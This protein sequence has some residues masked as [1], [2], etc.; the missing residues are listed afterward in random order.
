MPPCSYSDGPRAGKGSAT[1]LAA[2]AAGAEPEEQELLA[3]AAL[4]PGAWG[5][6][7]FAPAA[8]WQNAPPG[9]W[10][11]QLPPS[12]KVLRT[13]GHTAGGHSRRVLVLALRGVA[14]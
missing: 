11:P 8:P 7:G 9:I 10:H 4:V 14:A 13:G 2:A 6:S 1:A 3:V 5:P 12:G